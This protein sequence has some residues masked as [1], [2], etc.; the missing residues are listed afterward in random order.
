MTFGAVLGSVLP[1]V[2]AAQIA[3][4]ASVGLFSDQ[5]CSSCNLTIPPGDTGTL[6]VVAVDATDAI[7][8]GPGLSSAGMRIEGLPV[9]WNANVVRSPAAVVSVGDL[10]GDWAVVGFNPRE[11]SDHILLY[12]VTLTPGGGETSTILRVVKPVG[13]LPP[14]DCPYRCGPGDCPADPDC[15]CVDAGVLYVNTPGECLVAVTPATWT[16]VK[17]LYD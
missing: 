16:H 14:F 3:W 9:G 1:G 8:C 5:D 7:L 6:Y 15:A 10:F 12:T 2:L 13:S 11:L 4:G 17:A